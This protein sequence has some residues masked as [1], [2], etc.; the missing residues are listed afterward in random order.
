[1][2]FQFQQNAS[3][4]VVLRQAHSDPLA[5]DSCEAGGSRGRRLSEARLGLNYHAAFFVIYLL[6]L[7]L[8]AGCCKHKVSAQINAKEKATVFEA[9]AFINGRA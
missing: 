9:V 4:K 7:R 2:T 5:N 8:P 6:S 3:S 1:M